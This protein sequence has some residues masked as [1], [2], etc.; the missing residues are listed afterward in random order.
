LASIFVLTSAA[1]P[2]TGLL[3]DTYVVDIAMLRCEGHSRNLPL[4]SHDPRVNLEG[5]HCVI[6]FRRVMD[7]FDHN[8]VVF[9]HAV[10]LG[11][12]PASYSL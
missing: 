1:S 11:L 3:P 7:V 8:R 4:F 12:Q 2:L 10:Q 6:C 9:L 5:M